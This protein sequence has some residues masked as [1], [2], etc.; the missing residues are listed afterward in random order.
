[1][2]RYLIGLVVV[3]LLGF[4]FLDP[5]ADKNTRGNRMFHEGR[6]EEAL[7]YYREAQVEN[8]EAPELRFNA[9]D[10]YFKKNAYK[11][12]LQ[13]FG[14]ALKSRDPS[15]LARAYYNMGNVHVRQQNLQQAADA[16]KRSLA[17]QPDDLDAKVNLEWVLEKMREQEKQQKREQEQDENRD[18]DQD[19]NESGNEPDEKDSNDGGNGEQPD[20]DAGGNRDDNPEGQG[21][22]DQGQRQQPEDPA[23]QQQNKPSSQSA[24]QA[25]SLSREEAER[26]LDAMKDR[27]T[28]SQKYRRLRVHGKRYEGNEW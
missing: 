4:T 24:S 22:P 1:M 2:Y 26:L 28:K 27:E 11:D 20:Q 13:E 6:F 17:L 19:R 8:P 25:G 10:A 15:F 18:D 3:P 7:K 23:G 9:G 5:A 21:K 16:Y 12:A 14:Q